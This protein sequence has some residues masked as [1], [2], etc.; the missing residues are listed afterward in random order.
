MSSGSRHYDEIDCPRHHRVQRHRR[1]RAGDRAAARIADGFL[2]LGRRDR[3]TVRRL[4]VSSHRLCRWA[5]TAAPCTPTPTCRC[6]ESPAWSAEFL[7]RLD[8]RDVTLVGNDTGG[9]IVQLM[10]ADGDAADRA[11]RAGLLRRVRQLP[12]RPDREDAGADRQAPA[13]AVRAVHAAD[14]AQSGPPAAARLRLADQTRR[15]RHR[16]LDETLLRQPDIRRDAV[17]V[18]RA[19]SAEP[20]SAR[21][22]RRRATGIR[23]PG[24]GG[25][26]ERGPGH[27][28]RAR[29]PAGRSAPERATGRDTRQLHASP[30]GPAQGL[31]RSSRNS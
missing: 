14:A 7:D 11:D 31:R 4:P 12:A 20:D 22:R 15:R 18:L 30:A 26:G 16:A 19:I 5:R 24:P 8:L 3:R 27:A 23:P 29:T 17:R 10:A 9:A 2:A 28:T 25:L 13:R 6:P 1:R 21:R